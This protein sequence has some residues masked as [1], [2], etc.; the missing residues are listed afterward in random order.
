[1]ARSH[2]DRHVDDAR[3]ARAAE[4]LTRGLN[5]ARQL[6]ED[7]I[8]GGNPW[9]D[10][11]AARTVRLDGQPPEPWPERQT[12]PPP[13]RVCPQTGLRAGRSGPHLAVHRRPAHGRRHRIERAGPAGVRPPRRR[14]HRTRDPGQAGSLL[15]SRLRS[16][17]RPCRV[18]SQRPTLPRLPGRSAAPR[19][20]PCR[21]AAHP[22]SHRGAFSGRHHECDRG[23]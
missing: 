1:M 19:E 11:R 5:D 17:L 14:S 9:P 7:W 12:R 6:I 4:T 15:L 22:A 18:L 20:A 13:K 8:E 23:R 21:G 10:L 16:M 2:P 3:R